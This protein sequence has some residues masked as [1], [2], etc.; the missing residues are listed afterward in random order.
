MRQMLMP[1]A[2]WFK[3]YD[4][5]IFKEDA[6][7]GITVAAILTP[8]A[9]AYAMLAGLPPIVGFYTAL[10]GSVA[11]ALWGSS[12]RLSTGPVAIISFLVFSSLVPFAEP[13]SA[14][15]IVLAAALAV[16]SGAILLLLGLFRLGF[17]MRAIPHSVITGF[18]TA[19]A[20]IIAVTQI[21]ALLGFAVERY[22]FM[23]PT[24]GSILLNIIDMHGATVIVGAVSL[25]LL[26]LLKRFFVHVPSALVVLVLM[27][28][29]SY[30]FS[31]E[32]SGVAVVGSLSADLPSLGIP[33]L[34]LAAWLALLNKA[35]IIAL[36]GFVESYAIARTIAASARERIDVDQELVGQGMANIVA[37]LFRGYPVSGSFSRTAVNIAAG[38]R[39]G[40]ATICAAVVVMAALLLVTPV[41]AY[42]PLAVLAAIVIVSVIDLIDFHKLREM[43][44]LSRTDGLV[45]IVT[46]TVALLLKPDDAVAVGVI[47]ALALFL[48]RIVWARVRILG[49]EPEWGILQGADISP[50]TETFT[51]VLMLRI[52]TSAFYG[53]IEHIIRTIDSIIT[54]EESGGTT[55]RAVVL[56]C[57]SVTYM[58]LS[59]AETL[60]EYLESLHQER[61]VVYGIYMHGGVIER[62]RRVGALAHLTILHNIK[63]MRAALNLPAPTVEQKVE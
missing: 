50:Q 11:A 44:R 60:R 24:V 51:G 36:V 6:L 7:A 27:T 28:V 43:Y 21:P 16:L 32:A 2:Y 17:I 53:N 25:A 47:V 14:A 45:A 35:W 34:P 42:I 38:A 46:F 1:F 39:T 30:L 29:L 62:L 41:F 10:A 22:E 37:G 23:L 40:V 12:P 3:K 31:F 20:I 57:S 8:Q 58:D 48:R 61:I 59:G 52:E 26:F 55:V 19:A 54:D 15:Y 18:A 33:I 56:D 13:G 5:K 49:I 9:M 4:L 63:E